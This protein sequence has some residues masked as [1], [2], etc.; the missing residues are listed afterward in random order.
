M[1]QRTIAVCDDDKVSFLDDRDAG[2][3][4]CGRAAEGALLRGWS[5]AG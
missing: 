5:A 1:S 4:T 2:D 3:V